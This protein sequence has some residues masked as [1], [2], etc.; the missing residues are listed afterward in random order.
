MNIISTVQGGGPTPANLLLFDHLLHIFQRLTP[1]H[2]NPDLHANVINSPTGLNHNLT[3]PSPVSVNASTMSD[4]TR[5]GI[6]HGL[7]GLTP[8]VDNGVFGV[9]EN[10]LE[11]GRYRHFNHLMLTMANLTV[12]AEYAGLE[13]PDFDMIDYFQR[14]FEPK[15]FN[16]ERLDPWLGQ[17]HAPNLGATYGLPGGGSELI[18]NSEQLIDV[19]PEM[20]LRTESDGFV[21]TFSNGSITQCFGPCAQAERPYTHFM[22][23]NSAT[24]VEVDVDGF[25]FEFSE[26]AF[27]DSMR[28]MITGRGHHVLQLPERQA[29][30]VH[31]RRL[32]SLRD[33]MDVPRA[34]RV[35]DYKPSNFTGVEVDTTMPQDI[36]VNFAPRGWRGG[37]IHGGPETHISIKESVLQFKTWDAGKHGPVPKLLTLRPINTVADFAGLLPES[38]D[39][40]PLGHAS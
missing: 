9:L 34:I 24:P 7:S 19:L 13:D 28:V 17:F 27:H 39:P 11:N 21:V 32:E 38:G 36:P 12:D 30:V 16:A 35:R 33:F 2:R 3:I 22:H 31:N 1:R 20:S 37:G 5:T 18:V 25:D 4:R 10:L 14:T 26:I 23:A 40:I 6:A 15:G 29:W 8:N